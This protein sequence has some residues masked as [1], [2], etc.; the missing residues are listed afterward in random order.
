MKKFL[1]EVVKY[2]WIPLIMA[3]VSYIFFQLRDV[4]LGIITLVTL[5]AVYTLVRLYFAH[6]KWWLLIILVVVGFAAIA[7]FVI[8]APSITLSISGQKVT[9]TSI[10]F[11]AGSVSVSPAPQP[12]GL[13]TK[14]AIV[15]LTADPASGY[16]WKSWSG[17]NDDSSNPTTVTMVRNKQVKVTF[18]PRFSLVINN[19]AVIGSFVSFN[20]GSVL[21]NPAPKDDSKYPKDSAVTLTASPASGYRFVRWGADASG[22]VT[23]VTI[24][25]NSSKNVTAIFTKVYT[26]SISV[27]PAGGGS[28]SPGSSTYDE[29]TAATLTAS[30]A[31]GYRFDHWGGDASGNVT[32]VTITMNSNKNVTVIFVKIAP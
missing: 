26:L 2:F 11:A 30:P 10:S 15:I 31:S 23:A 13:Y 9:D 5:S 22:N 18:E 19:Q 14:N 28:V 27:N 12:N 4:L 3:L 6:K 7:F 17:T 29:G 8:R 21:V 24:T 32:A 16:D 20:E 1:E 25:M